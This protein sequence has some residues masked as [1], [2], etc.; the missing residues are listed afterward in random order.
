MKIHHEAN[1]RLMGR[2]T[3][4]TSELSVTTEWARDAGPGELRT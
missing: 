3:A 2:C 1:N 4:S